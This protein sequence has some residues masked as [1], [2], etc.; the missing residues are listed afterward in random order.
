[1]KKGT[2]STRE[3]VI[4]AVMLIVVL[5]G[6]YDFFIASSSKSVGAGNGEDVEQIDTLIARVSGVLAGSASYSVY[7]AIVAETEEEWARDPFYTDTVPAV[8]TSSLGPVAYTGYLEIGTRKMAVIDG[9]S[10]ETGDELEV[11]GY[12]VKRIGPS[13]VVIEEKGTGK[14]VTVPLLEE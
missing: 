9:M 3:I 10:Y 14:S 2:V 13:A 11:G 5:Y 7:A 8:S 1:M 4:M 6:A 12:H